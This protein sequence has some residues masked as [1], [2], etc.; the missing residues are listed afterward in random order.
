MHSYKVY[1]D[2]T[3]DIP[4]DLQE[5]FRIGVL[6]IPVTIGDQ[7]FMSGTELDNVTFFQMMDE[8]SGIPVTSQITPYVFEELYQKE[9]QAGRKNLLLF[10][11]N[12]RGSATYNNAVAARE[13]FYAENEG[14]RDQMNI[15]LFD[16][17]SYSAGYGYP[18]IIAAQKL[19]MGIPVDE[20]LRLTE[21][22][23]TKQCIYFGLY[24]LKYAG[25]SGRIPSA[26]VFVGEALGIKPIMKLWD[27]AITTEGKARGDK[28]LVREI[29]KMVSSDME[30]KTPYH[31]LYG[32]DETARDEMID[33]MEK[34]IG[35]P[36]QYCFQ[37]G[38][39]I[40]IN[41][42]HKAVGVCFQ[43]KHKK[44]TKE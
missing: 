17:A 25:K 1:V 11:I 3:A 44:K 6:P 18:A 28:K 9:Y 37:I 38:P 39:A 13:A 19:E 16:G 15:H 31:V 43:M 10:L 26:A 33:E 21:K 30:P 35:Y 27:H 41:A 12:S 8:F 36:P 42:G 29:V 2:A 32:S 24:S 40:A 14:A 5:R 22:L 4:K 34:K 20:V 7:S 23:L